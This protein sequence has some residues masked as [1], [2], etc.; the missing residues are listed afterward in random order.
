MSISTKWLS[1]MNADWEIV[2]PKSLFVERSTRSY[3]DDVHLTPSQ[4][5]GVLPQAEYM[6]KNGTG[7]V[8]NLAGADNM[9]HV[10]PDDFI[11]HLRSFQ[12]GLEHSSF[13]GKVSNAYCV[14]K[15]VRDVEPRFFRWVFKSGGYIQELNSTTNQLRDGQSIKFEQFVSIGLPL[16]AISEQIRMANFLDSQISLV[17]QL[18]AHR[19]I[20]ISLV[21]ENVS[22]KMFDKFL[23]V[24][25]KKIRLKRLI[26][27]EKLGIWGEESGVNPVEVLVARVADFNR[28][29]FRLNAVETQRSIEISQ[30]K[31]RKIEKGDI[32]LER[33]GGGEKSPVGCAVYVSE[34][35]PN[36]VC[37]NFVSRVRPSYD[38]DS[39]YLSLLFAA[40]YSN[41]MQRPHSSQTTGIQNLDTESYFQTEVPFRELPEQIELA[42]YGSELLGSA[43]EAVEFLDKSIIAMQNYKNSLI[44]MVV[45]GSFDFSSERG[46][47]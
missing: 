32:L 37:S 1:G 12:G 11:I 36:L 17:D 10:E 14:L 19:K 2:N 35:F 13:R 34:E 33:S 46:V 30:F 45:T 25:E 4:L 26:S 16:P 41:G 9:K 38:V 42:R 15:S 28:N 47:A 21:W 5:Y 23:G 40:L 22:A 20:Q 39:E 29:V 6:E 8:L 7:V 31:T 43:A 24:G 18:I 27:T 44:T 3:P